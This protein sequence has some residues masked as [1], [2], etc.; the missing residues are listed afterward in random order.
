[1]FQY[2]LNPCRGDE[3][4]LSLRLYNGAS[5]HNT[6]SEFSSE[7]VHVSLNVTQTQ[8]CLLK[9]DLSGLDVMGDR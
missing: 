9:H 1:M 2:G 5:L 4:R 8:S 6:S 3:V 7:Q